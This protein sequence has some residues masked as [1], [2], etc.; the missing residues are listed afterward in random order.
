MMNTT[1][2]PVPRVADLKMSEMMYELRVRMINTNGIP[3]PMTPIRF[4]QNILENEVIDGVNP[5]TAFRHSGTSAESILN[6]AKQC[7]C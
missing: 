4:L 5:V 7:L 6:E 1:N 3:P 2:W